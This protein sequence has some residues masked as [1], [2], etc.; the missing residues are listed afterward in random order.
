MQDL[1]L[2]E[3]TLLFMRVKTVGGAD[4]AHL[5][6]HNEPFQ[7][8]TNVHH[9]CCQSAMYPVLGVRGGRATT[10]E[11]LLLLSFTSMTSYP[12]RLVFHR[13]KSLSAFTPTVS[14]R[15]LQKTSPLAGPARLPATRNRLV[16]QPEL[17]LM[18]QEAEKYQNEDEAYKAKFEAR[19]GLVNN[20]FM[21]RIT[22]T[23]DISRHVVG[24]GR[25]E[26][27]TG[28]RWT[29][30][31]WQRKLSSKAI[32]MGLEGDVNPIMMKVYWAAGGGDDTPRSGRPGGCLSGVAYGGGTTF[33]VEEV[34]TSGTCTL[35]YHH[36]GAGRCL[37]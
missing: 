21:S 17:D 19:S 32:Y 30:I 23:E 31:R 15:C 26:L 5:A 24:A 20:R 1:L 25:E 8:R 11:D 6:E 36:A 7:E 37:C 27:E 13:L 12:F 18:A 35:Q 3:I 28:G 33:T 9:L 22:L 10:K 4:R 2:L 29:I 14:S 16:S 34:T